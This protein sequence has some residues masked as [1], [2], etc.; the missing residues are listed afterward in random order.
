MFQKLKK[1]KMPIDNKKFKKMKLNKLQKS[2]IKFQLLVILNKYY[3][4]KVKNKNNFK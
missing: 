3:I 1:L 2:L 4:K